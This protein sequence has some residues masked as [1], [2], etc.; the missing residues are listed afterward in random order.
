MFA[1]ENE[2]DIPEGGF[3]YLSPDVRHGGREPFAENLVFFWV[4]F[5]N[6][7]NNFP[8]TGM[9]AY[10]EKMAAVFETLLSEQQN[11]NDSF[12][13]RK[14]LSI[15]LYETTLQP[16]EKTAKSNVQNNLAAS[17][18]RILKLRYTDNLSTSAIAQMLHCNADYLGRL[19]HKT[20]NLSLLDDL[21]KI[22]LKHAA[23]C[24]RE[25]ASSVKEI[26]FSC[27][28]NDIAY[29]RRRFFREF[30]MRPVE[31][32]KLYAENHINTE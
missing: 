4:H 26:A 21:N 14:L 24:L 7:G 1:A 29:F 16:S 2:Y 6:C 15:L 12:V 10:P 30:S 22:R 28:Y 31:Y 19:Y 11:R 18:R 23:K 20:Y 25:T 8:E 32:R 5:E 17:A 13:C 27:G 9:A 3:L